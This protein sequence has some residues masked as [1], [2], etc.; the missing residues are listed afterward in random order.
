MPCSP[1]ACLGVST[2]GLGSQGPS[3]SSRPPCSYATPT[4]RAQA[5]RWEHQDRGCS[6][7][8]Q[9]GAP[10]STGQGARPQTLPRGWCGGQGYRPAPWL[11]SLYCAGPSLGVSVVTSAPSCASNRPF[12]WNHSIGQQITQAR[13]SGSVFTLTES[14]RQPCPPGGDLQLREAG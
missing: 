7:P 8:S 3:G 2:W 12:S 4:L 13:V 1:G 6:L 5:Q 11:P 14:L 9:M 10:V